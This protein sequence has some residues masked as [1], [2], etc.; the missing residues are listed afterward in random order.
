MAVTASA[1]PKVVEDIQNKLSF[2]YSNVIRQSFKR[3]NIHYQVI[4]C[5]NKSTVLEKVLKKNA[6]YIR[7]K[8]KES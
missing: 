8:Q 1:T 6:L 5:E 4:Q 7:K 3:S 2:R